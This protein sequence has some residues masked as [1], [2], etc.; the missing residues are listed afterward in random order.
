[1][2]S[3]ACELV[4]H[5]R[6]QRVLVCSA[7]H[8]Y[9]TKV[10]RVWSELHSAAV[11]WFIYAISLDCKNLAV[12][13]NP[14]ILSPPDPPACAVGVWLHQ[15]T[16]TSNYTAII[17]DD[18]ILTSLLHSSLKSPETPFSSA[19]NLTASSSGTIMA[20]THDLRLSP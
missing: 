4:Q 2:S 8:T 18:I 16:S 13:T 15:T 10:A 6:R 3:F 1:M 9:F 11:T 7:L 14:G 12:S 5:V 17:V 19:H 20:T